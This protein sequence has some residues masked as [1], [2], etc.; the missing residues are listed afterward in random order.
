MTLT[1][2]E[3]GEYRLKNALPAHAH[4]LMFGLKRILRK[5]LKMG[6]DRNKAKGRSNVARFARMPHQ[7]T[8]SQN[9][10]TLSIKAKA[11]LADTNARYNGYNNGDIDFSLKTMMKWGWN[12]NDTITKAKNELLAK[13]WLVLTRQGGRNCC[14]LYAL[15]LWPIDECNGKLD[16]TATNKALAY[17]KKGNNPEY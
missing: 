17:W 12:S 14:N 2:K 5:I 7:V 1:Q 4:Y 10:R 11:L 15:T 3:H 13:G 8:N 9:Y 6:I 16:R